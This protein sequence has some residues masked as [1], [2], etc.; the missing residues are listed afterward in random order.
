LRFNEVETTLIRGHWADTKAVN[1]AKQF[2]QGPRPVTSGPLTDKIVANLTPPLKG[3]RITWD[4]GTG[5]G[6]RVTSAGARAFILRYRNAAGHDK[7]ITIGGHPAWNVV[8]ARRHADGLRRAI[9]A[10]SD[11]LS[12]RQALRGAP[13]VA[14]LA[15]RFE[16]EHL[17]KRRATTARDYR[18]MLARQ[19][20]PVLGR[21][22]VMD[23]RTKDVE[24]LHANIAQT[25]PYMANRVVAVL[26]KMFS[27][28]IKWEMRT[29]NPVMGIERAPEHRRERFL[30]PAEIARLSEALIAH[31][32]KGSANAVR[33]LLLTGAR[34]GEVLSAS[35]Q[36]FN[37]ADGVWAKPAASTKQKKEHRIPLSASALLLV[38]QMKAEADRENERR[39]RDGVRPDR[40][41]FPGK[42][43]KPQADIKKFWATICAKAGIEGVRLHDLRH[44]HAAILASLGLSL[45][46]IGALLGHTQPATTQRYAHIM[47]DPLRAAVER[48]GS[49]I[50]GAVQV[51]AEVVLPRPGAS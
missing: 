51:D 22:K 12:Q 36:Q 31:P 41:L 46:I 21:K 26:S 9:D 8:K 25:A 24:A 20:R 49:A 23:V 30:N 4:G 14:E 32:A 38:T 40:F 28:A 48:A 34:R 29:D 27:L 45:P 42:D 43:G 7:Q 16:A 13:T 3:N 2:S 39:V 10:G 5:F 6:V 37:L 17:T 19:I 11:P 1:M 33:L 47:D 44:T 50:S 15:D 35:W 18:A